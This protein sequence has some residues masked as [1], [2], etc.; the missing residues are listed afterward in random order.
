MLESAGRTR[1][2]QRNGTV[3][4]PM[5]RTLARESYTDAW[6]A[7]KLGVDPRELDGRRRAGE[8]LGVPRAGGLDYAYPSWQ[9]DPDGRPLPG[10]PRIVQAARQAGLDERSLYEFLLRRDGMTG[11]GRLVDAVREGREDRVLD[12]IRTLPRGESGAHAR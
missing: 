10:I 11:Q 1:M 12:L 7:T 5:E 2:M 8:L 3:T 4:T 6:L 9:F